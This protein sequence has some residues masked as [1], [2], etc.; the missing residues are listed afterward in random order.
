M[1][2]QIKAICV[3]CGAEFE[4]RLVKANANYSKFSERKTCSQKC[5]ATYIGKRM[6][7][8]WAA[9]NGWVRRRPDHG[10]RYSG[11]PVNEFTPAREMLVKAVLEGDHD[12]FVEAQRQ[13][14]TMLKAKL[15]LPI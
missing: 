4:R 10:Q 14:R 13:L 5:H 7:R 12:S 9:R 3:V 1:H 11:L 8:M 2:G 6:R 15:D